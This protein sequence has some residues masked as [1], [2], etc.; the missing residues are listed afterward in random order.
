MKN[1]HSAKPEA[2][3]ARNFQNTIGIL[4]KQYADLL[5]LREQVRLLESAKNNCD[6]TSDL[7][8]GRSARGRLSI[9]L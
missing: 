3:R 6:F 1:K 5:R 2:A 4:S 8:A 9:V 7:R